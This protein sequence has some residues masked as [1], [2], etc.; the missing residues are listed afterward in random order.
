MKNQENGKLSVQLLN[1]ILL[2]LLAVV[3]LSGALLHPFPEVLAIRIL[4]ELSAILLVM[5]VIV[6]VVQH[7][8]KKI[9]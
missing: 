1:K 3:F 8:R 5:G 4:H 6:H 9:E 2:G 7:K